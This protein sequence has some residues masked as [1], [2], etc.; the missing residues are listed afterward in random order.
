MAGFFVSKGSVMNTVEE[1]M[2]ETLNSW[3]TASAL[4]YNEKQSLKQFDIRQ[5]MSFVLVRLRRSERRAWWFLGAYFVLI[6]ISSAISAF[7]DGAFIFMLVLCTGLIGRGQMLRDASIALAKMET[8]A[9][10]WL[11]QNQSSLAE[12]D[13][14]N[15]LAAK[16]QSIAAVR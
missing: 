1:A 6:L 14:A 16:N 8:L 7:S 15:R 13:A 2:R 10:L 9:D 3:S 12:F 11:R 4:T 5:Q